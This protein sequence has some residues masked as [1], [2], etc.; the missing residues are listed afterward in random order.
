MGVLDGIKVVE[1]AEQGFVPSC[2]AVLGDWGADVVKIER[3]TGD[4][5]A[6]HHGRRL[7]GRHR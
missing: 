7:R 3:P 5:A 1:L 4:P 2:G 6:G